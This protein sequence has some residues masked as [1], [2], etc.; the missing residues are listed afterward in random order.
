MQGS[1]HASA[2]CPVHQAPRASPPR[3]PQCTTDCYVYQFA[4]SMWRHFRPGQPWG[5]P[6]VVALRLA[7]LLGIQGQAIQSALRVRA[8]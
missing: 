1:E 2:C 4:P 6:T 8:L 5:V 7:P 3:G